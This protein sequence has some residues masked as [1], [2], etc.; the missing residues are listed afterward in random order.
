MIKLLDHLQMLRT[1]RLSEN[2]ERQKIN[3]EK[4]SIC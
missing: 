1:I 2:F 4:S 3:F